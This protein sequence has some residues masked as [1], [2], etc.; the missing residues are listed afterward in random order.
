VAEVVALVAEVG[1]ELG[2]FFVFSRQGQL[3]IEGQDRQNILLAVSLRPRIVVL[4]NRL[5][6]FLENT[7]L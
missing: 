7:R 6:L 2:R 1:G 5:V 3:D 4:N